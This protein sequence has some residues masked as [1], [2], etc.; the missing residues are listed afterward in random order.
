MADVS[1][2]LVKVKKGF[3]RAYKAQLEFSKSLA[4]L[5]KVG[6]RKCVPIGRAQQERLSEMA[7]IIL[8][9]AWEQFL[10]N[11]FIT[12]TVDAPLATFKR[13]HR[14]LVTDFDTAHDLIRGSQKYVEWA[15]SNRV[16]ERAKVFFR[17]GEPFESAL[18][19]ISDELMKM[20]TVRN[21]CAHYSQH[22]KKQYDKMIRKV[23]G[24]T[25]HIVP[26]RLLLSAPPSAL[27]A[28]SGAA[29]YSSVFELY[30]EILSTASSQIVPEKSK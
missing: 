30:C 7:F 26:G 11:S 21:R 3:E 6:G 20:R 8:F 14:V 28:V 23:Y 25:K 24:A 10:E 22:A 4:S 19:A 12:L 18:S 27:S 13:R 1:P 17:G 29:S 5:Q 16:R 9:T 2:R 15:D